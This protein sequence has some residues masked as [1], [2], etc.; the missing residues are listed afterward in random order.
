MRFYNSLQTL[1][2]LPNILAILIVPGLVKGADPTKTITKILTVTYTPT[3]EQLQPSSINDLSTSHAIVPNDDVKV[4][5]RVVEFQPTP[6]EQVSPLL[7][8]AP[9]PGPARE[10]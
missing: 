1:I 4:L 2:F 6:N 8:P 3:I 10:Y 9:S 7:T 5:Q